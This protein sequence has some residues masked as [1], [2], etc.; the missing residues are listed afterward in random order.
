MATARNLSAILPEM[1]EQDP[2]CDVDEWAA[3]CPQAIW[4]Q[5][6]LTVGNLSRGGQVTLRQ[7]GP[8]RDKAGRASQSYPLERRR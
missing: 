3:H 1:V 6:F 5:V 8:G 7:Q 2:D 4:N